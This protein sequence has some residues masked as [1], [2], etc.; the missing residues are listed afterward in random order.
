MESRRIPDSAITASSERIYYLQASKARLHM[1][2]FYP[3]LPAGWSA[4]VSDKKQWLEINLEMKT[5]VTGI[6]T[7]GLSSRWSPDQWVTSYQVSYKDD[8][9]TEWVLYKQRRHVKVFVT[10]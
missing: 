8:G 3:W 6:G 9:D 5:K 1:R 7:Q 4:S 2:A 10:F